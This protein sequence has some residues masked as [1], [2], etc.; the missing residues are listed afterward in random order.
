MSESRFVAL[1]IK[2]AEQD[3]GLRILNEVVIRQAAQI[4][5]LQSRIAQLAERLDRL[6]D[7]TGKFS[8][9]EEVPPHY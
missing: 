9:A 4:E 8:A 7:G 1:E 2:F 6:G 3:D 5:Q